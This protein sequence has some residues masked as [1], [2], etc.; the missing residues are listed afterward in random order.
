[1]YVSLLRR[2]RCA[3]ALFRIFRSAPRNLRSSALVRG[4][5]SGTVTLCFMR[6]SSRSRPE[7]PATRASP[8]LGLGCSDR[9]SGGADG[10]G[11]ID[12]DSWGNRGEP[13]LEEPP[14][15]LSP[16]SEAMSLESSVSP[17]TPESETRPSKSIGA[18]S[19]WAGPS[20][21]PSPLRP[22]SSSSIPLANA[23]ERSQAPS[24]SG[25]ISVSIASSGGD[26]GVA[27]AHPNGAVSSE[28]EAGRS[29]SRS[30]PFRSSTHHS[31]LTRSIVALGSAV[32][33]TIAILDP[34]PSTV[35]APPSLLPHPLHR[36]WFSRC[37]E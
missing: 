23:D 28:S 25:A 35:A 33:S 18:R 27:A 31:R 15:K 34:A 32:L 1:M 4:R 24:V 11:L 6:R 16:I 12:A 26:V 14:E 8:D 7:M 36:Q 9:T 22:R 19:I 29:E 13:D 5:C 17:S 21:W 2:D 37:L 3:E 10:D 20:R 30:T